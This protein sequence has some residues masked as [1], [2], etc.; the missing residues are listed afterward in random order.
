MSRA[1]CEG[2][3]ISSL[4]C[5]TIGKPIPFQEKNIHAL[6]ATEANEANESFMKPLK[7]REVGFRLQLHEAAS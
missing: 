1:V 2:G 3:E 4:L 5:A 6:E 7:P